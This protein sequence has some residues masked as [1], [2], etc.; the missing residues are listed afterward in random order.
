MT[1]IRCVVASIVCFLV[2]GATVCALSCLFIST[3]LQQVLGPRYSEFDFFG[4]IGVTVFAS[5]IACVAATVAAAGSL[6]RLRSTFQTRNLLVLV[7]VPMLIAFVF[8]FTVS[9]E[10][11]W[12]GLIHLS[13]CLGILA[14]AGSVL[15]MNGIWHRKEFSPR[16]HPDHKI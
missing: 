12:L 6:V 1:F 7:L 15:L 4:V 10:W 5:L 2:G 14:G 8:A 9:G 11:A 16:L 13:A 3:P